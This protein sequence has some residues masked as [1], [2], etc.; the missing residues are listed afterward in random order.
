MDGKNYWGEVKTSD[1]EKLMSL[2]LSEHHIFFGTPIESYM[3][4]AI[5][6]H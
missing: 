1:V 6:T 4:N 3:R 5:K 2:I